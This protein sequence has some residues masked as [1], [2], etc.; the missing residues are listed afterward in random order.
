MNAPIF[1][2]QAFAR[3]VAVEVAHLLEQSLG[4]DVLNTEQAAALL[5]L[6]PD[7][8]TSLA[9]QGKLPARKIGRDWRYVR[10]QLLQHVREGRQSHD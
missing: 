9:N 10:S 6:H 3:L 4:D 5:K 8:V 1:D 2:V 7:T